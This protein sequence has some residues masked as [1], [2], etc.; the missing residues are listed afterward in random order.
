MLEILLVIAVAAGASLLTFFSGFGLGTMLLPVFLLFFPV[1]LAIAMTAVIHFLNNIFKTGLIGG[2]AV[3]DVVLKFGI[4]AFLF[5]FLGAKVLAYLASF[6]IRIPY[7]LFGFPL[8][9]TL[10]NVVIG[11]LLLIFAIVEIVPSKNKKPIKD[12]G[13]AI[14]GAVSG[15]F[16]GVSGHQGALRSGFLIRLGL[17][18]EAFVAT[19]IL[20][21]LFVDISRLGVYWTNLPL[22]EL[23]DHKW[24]LLAALL[25][26][27]TGAI[28]G[29]R[30]LKKVTLRVLQY[31]VAAGISVIG[32]L[33]IIGAI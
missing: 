12:I 15:F 9:T 6:P 25:A 3:R 18:K 11:L 10:V 5:A 7:K 29:R 2:H 22:S 31:F 17:S 20:I 1:D 23:G 24:T 19:G 32:V 28:I 33:L 16:G 27:F 14:G 8:T 26:A 30:M 21:S 13:L 4:P